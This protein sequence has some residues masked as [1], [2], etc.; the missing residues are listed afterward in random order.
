MSRE[1]VHQQVSGGRPQLSVEVIESRWTPMVVGWGKLDPPAKTHW[2]AAEF[3]ELAEDLG[4]VSSDADWRAAEVGMALADFECRHGK[5]EH[6]R[7]QV[8]DCF[9][10]AVGDAVGEWLGIRPGDG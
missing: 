1:R 2:G 4:R 3:S 8:C 10:D 6:D 5:M 7:T 9:G